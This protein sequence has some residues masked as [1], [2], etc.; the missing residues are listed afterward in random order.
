MLKKRIIGVVNVLN[1]WAVQSFGYKKYLPLGKAEC[2]IENLDRWG[3]DEILIQ[4]FDRSKNN[5]GPDFDL[6]EKIGKLGIGTPLVY[7]G[8]IR[9]END[10]RKAIQL[11]AD[12]IL[13][14]ALLHVDL[15][16]VEKISEQL[17]AQAVI[18]TLPLGISNGDLHWYDY[19][20]GSLNKLN[21][22]L[23][24]F[25]NKGCTSEILLVDYM[26]EG[27]IKSFNPKLVEA[28]QE[29]KSPLILFGG[30][31]DTDQM[32]TLLASPR[33]NA[34]ACGNSLSYEE[35]RIQNIKEHLNLEYIRK[36]FYNEAT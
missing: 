8:G 13:V 12:R 26:N 2:I 35:L 31:T 24:S 1:G 28:I 23:C 17:G 25:L 10:A 36:P 20:S 30:I 4:A 19:R 3:A 11:G 15:N 5:L 7:G 9:D 21:E 6:L 27:G 22:K 16:G 33:V 29:L 14:D 32:K 34:I 18:T